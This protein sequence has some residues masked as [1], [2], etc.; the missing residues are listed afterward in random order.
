MKNLKK[1]RSFTL[2]ELLVVIV[3]IGILAGVIA[4]STSSAITSSQN[5]KLVANL[6]NISKALEGYSSYP[7]DSLCIEDTTKN[8]N[9]LSSLGIENY[10]KHPNYTN[11]TAL[12]TN[13]CFPIQ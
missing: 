9:F 11:G 1:D 8:S 13:N 10:P 12:T 4:I 2:I 5:A 3:I 6:S 7:K